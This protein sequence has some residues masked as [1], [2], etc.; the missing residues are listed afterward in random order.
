MSSQRQ[1][2]TSLH[3]YPLP[4][5]P[6][7]TQEALLQQLLRKKLETKAEDWIEE[8]VHISDDP[9]SN[10]AAG[11][12]KAEDMRDL[13]SSAMEIQQA[14]VA[15][16]TE[17]Q[18]WDDDYTIRER[19]MGVDKVITGL[20]RKLDQGEEDEEDDDDDDDVDEDGE[21]K[22]EKDDLVG[23]ADRM[24]VD[25]PQAPAVAGLTTSLP[26]LLLDSVLKYAH[27]QDVP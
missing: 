16:L 11:V 10:G 24:D 6:G 20:K 27:G 2:F 23:E 21:G 13:W 5:F 8:S 25:G 9:R 1:L 14:M 15:Q 18:V 3:V 7:D 17:D 26:P 19:E 22:A 4:T 12:L